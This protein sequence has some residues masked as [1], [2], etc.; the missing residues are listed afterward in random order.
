MAAPAM[1]KRSIRL[2]SFKR[3]ASQ[4]VMEQVVED[5][6]A[7][8]KRNVKEF[9]SRALV[10]PTAVSPDDDDQSIVTLDS[11]AATIGSH[12]PFSPSSRRPALSPLEARSLE[13]DDMLEPEGAEE[14]KAEG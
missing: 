3:T 12:N 2:P 5:V 14:S 1:R 8:P 6:E 13:L 7:T 11:A 4:P 10:K 9:M